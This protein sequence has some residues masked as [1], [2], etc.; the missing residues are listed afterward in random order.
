MTKSIQNYILLNIDKEATNYTKLKKY[1]GTTEDYFRWK[2]K[3]LIKYPKNSWRHRED[4]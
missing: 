3:K 1:H 4:I 2:N